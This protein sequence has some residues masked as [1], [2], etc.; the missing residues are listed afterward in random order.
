MIAGTDTKNLTETDAILTTGGALTVADAD[1]PATFVAQSH[2]GSNGYG[3]F[4]IDTAG[5]WTYS[6]TAAHNEFIDG[7]TYTDTLTVMSSDGTP[8]VLTVNILG[9]NDAAVIGGTDTRNLTE[10]NA[11]TDHR[12]RVDHQRCRQPGDVQAQSSAAEQR[13]RHLHDRH[14]RQLEL[15]TPLGA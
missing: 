13:L 11:D 4:A 3:T 15:H 2:A 7:Q 9:A 10:T 14:R 5:N 6:T 12:R 8:H 1:S